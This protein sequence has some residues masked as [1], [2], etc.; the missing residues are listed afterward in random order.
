MES[1]EKIVNDVINGDMKA[2][3]KLY[4]ETSKQVYYTCLSFLKNEQ[5][6]LDIMQDTYISALTHLQELID[7]NRFCQWVNQIAVNKCKNYLIKNKPVLMDDEDME[8][9][10]MEENDN[11]LP[12]NYITNQEKRKLLLNI[13]SE[14]LSVVQYQTIILYYFDGLSVQEIANSMDCPIGTVTYRLSTARGKIKQG[15][16]EYENINGEKL[17]SV[18]GI[19]LLTAL[20]LAETKNLVVPNVLAKITGVALTSTA[21]T[22]AV[23]ATKGISTASS[24]AASATNGISATTAGVSTAS[25]TASAAAKT[26]IGALLGT[27]KAKI[28]AGVASLAV[29]GGVATGAFMLSKDNTPEQKVEAIYESEY[30]SVEYKSAEYDDCF[31]GYANG[32]IM[33]TMT[34]ENKTDETIYINRYMFCVNGMSSSEFLVYNDEIPDTLVPGKNEI[35]LPLSLNDMKDEGYI[36]IS[37]AQMVLDL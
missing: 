14:S 25:A 13:M 31:N 24:A 33:L 6:A 32:N 15:V 11:F 20:F 27:A 4:N 12:E 19:P 28:I 7:K 10:P 29:I 18:S 26:G 9:L 35:T 17:Y 34:I 36:D 23:S 3:E 2:F 22:A 8:Q 30:I 37:S 16:M 5:D 21:S 1:T